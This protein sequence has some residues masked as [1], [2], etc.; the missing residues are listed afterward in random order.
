MDARRTADGA[1]PTFGWDSLTNAERRIADL[2]S[3]GT[4]TRT[5]ATG[6]T[7]LTG[8]SARTCTGFFQSSTSLPVWN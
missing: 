2:V 7:C 6:C 4:R 5:S 1:R 3:Q 8:L